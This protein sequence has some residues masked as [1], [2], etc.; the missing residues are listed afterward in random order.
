MQAREAGNKVSSVALLGE[1]RQQQESK[2][3]TSK[4]KKNVILSTS[5][6]KPD[7]HQANTNEAC[8]SDNLTQQQDVQSASCS[9]SSPPPSRSQSEILPEADNIMPDDALNALYE[10]MDTLD[11]SASQ[12]NQHQQQDGQL[13]SHPGSEI[14]PHRFHVLSLKCLT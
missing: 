1:L 14:L 3:P 13:V 6:T 10:Q 11:A 2:Q 12:K 9:N 8:D 4:S 7:D 5:D